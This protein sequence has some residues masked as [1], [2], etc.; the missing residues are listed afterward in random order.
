MSN[1]QAIH[2][3][4]LERKRENFE[5]S[6]RKYPWIP[7][8][9][10]IYDL[11][12]NIDNVWDK[13]VRRLIEQS[14]HEDL[15]YLN[16]P[17]KRDGRFKSKK[18]QFG[19]IRA[20]K[21]K[22][23][24]LN[25]FLSDFEDIS[26]EEYDLFSYFQLLLEK[27]ENAAFTIKTLTDDLKPLY[28]NDEGAR[29]RTVRQIKDV[30]NTLEKHDILK[31][32]WITKKTFPKLDR[33][34]PIMRNTRM[35]YPGWIEDETEEKERACRRVLRQYHWFFENLG[36]PKKKE[37]IQDQTQLDPSTWID[38]L[39]PKILKNRLKKFLES[40]IDD[41]LDF[42]NVKRKEKVQEK[43]LT[44]VQEAIDRC[45]DPK[46]RQ[47]KI[48]HAMEQ[49]VPQLLDLKIMKEGFMDRF[50][51]LI[52]SFDEYTRE[53]KAGAILDR[54]AKQLLVGKSGVALP[55]GEEK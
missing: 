31:M 8:P 35:F 46:L 18:E 3:E 48:E 4:N 42:K 13:R 10:T 55:I 43:L 32:E 2:S 17:K 6:T 14:V 24:N 36:C 21:L 54:D 19:Y 44:K 9:V 29:S 53:L 38:D 37:D 40:E 5:T 22:Y 15:Q 25:Y 16:S 23:R 47:E 49:V 1:L 7:D 27:E 39:T 30:S 20:M 41:A 34:S 52:T 50:K 12:P 11:I 51:I 26:E 28:A 45:Q 33:E